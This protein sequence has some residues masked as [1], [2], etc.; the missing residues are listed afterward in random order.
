MPRVPYTSE[1]NPPN[2]VTG[3]QW[4]APEQVL[5]AAAHMNDM[6]RLFEGGGGRFS[7]LKG[8][9]AKSKPSHSLK[10]RK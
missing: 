6:G 9:G 10:V 8:I 1:E 7:S 4:V 3:D 2:P 5:M